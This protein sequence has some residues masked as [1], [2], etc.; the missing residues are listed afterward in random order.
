M[1][2][3][4]QTHFIENLHKQ[5]LEICSIFDNVFQIAQLFLNLWNINGFKIDVY[6][7]TVELRTQN[8]KKN[9]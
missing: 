3:F 7:I 1:C 5:G 2:H 8:K 6:L 9:G 4:S